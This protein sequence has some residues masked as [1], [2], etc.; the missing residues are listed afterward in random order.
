MLTKKGHEPLRTHRDVAEIMDQYKNTLPEV[1]DTK[2]VMV[3]K[4]GVAVAPKPVV[5]DKEDITDKDKEEA[6]A[7]KDDSASAGTATL[8]IGCVDFADNV[9]D[10]AL[11][12]TGALVSRVKAGW[13]KLPQRKIYVYGHGDSRGTAEYNRKLSK[14]RAEF[15]RKTHRSRYSREPHCREGCGQSATAREERRHR[16]KAAEEPS[17]RNLPVGAC[18]SCSRS[19]RG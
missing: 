4:G 17:Q 16:G 15:V 7:K 8:N 1:M 2:F 9:H 3:A 5:A 10:K 6:E 14:L 11:G 13:K 18:Q 12:D 19:G